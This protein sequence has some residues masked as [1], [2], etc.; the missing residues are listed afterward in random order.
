MN[1]NRYAKHLNKK[2]DSARNRAIKKPYFGKP[3]C[4]RYD[5]P[6]VSSLFANAKQ[7]GSSLFNQ[8]MAAIEQER[9][10]GIR[11]NTTFQ[12]Y[13]LLKTFAPSQEEIRAHARD[14]GN[15][16]YDLPIK[17]SGH[18]TQAAIEMNEK[19]PEHFYPRHWAGLTMMNY[20]LRSKCVTKDDI[21][22][23]F[24]VFRQVHYTTAKENSKLRKFQNADI[25]VDWHIAYREANVSQLIQE[26]D[27]G[28]IL[29]LENLPKS[30]S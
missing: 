26:K 14:L 30:C 6:T 25:F 5:T 3:E 27:C 23:F 19:V 21:R 9:K 20:F 11:V 17:W 24:E 4:K 10:I 12:K 16:I 2:I 15:T 7:T 28:N 22:L 29:T 13:S 8:R 1:T 18:R